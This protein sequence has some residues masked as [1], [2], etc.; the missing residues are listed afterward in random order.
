MRVLCVHLGSFSGCRCCFLF[1]G[2]GCKCFGLLL[3]AL[4]ELLLF[5]NLDLSDHLFGL[6]Q[7]VLV[8]LVRLKIARRFGRRY[9]H[10]LCPLLD[11]RLA[12][13]DAAEFHHLEQA[14][15]ER[16]AVEAGPDALEGLPDLLLARPLC[17]L[18]LLEDACRGRR[19]RILGGRIGV[20]RDRVGIHADRRD[21]GLPD[22]LA[23]LAS[24]ELVVAPHDSGVVL[25]QAEREDR[26]VLVPR[27]NRDQ[28]RL[29]EEIDQET[30]VHWQHRR[31]WVCLV[32]VLDRIRYGFHR[33][34]DA[35]LHPC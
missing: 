29:R 34:V 33:V 24:H 10:R 18:H 26:V 2:F 19:L 22:L 4:C 31:L 7:L 16:E 1:G 25:L 15:A 9:L 20:P 12:H 5:T 32:K 28:V 8:N 30:P 23:L 6:L 11:V 14:D 17:A 21:E 13:V 35:V 27:V 3:Q